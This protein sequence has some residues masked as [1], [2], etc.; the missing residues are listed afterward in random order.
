[1][2]NILKRHK[3][4]LSKKD[5]YTL[6]C[7]FYNESGGLLSSA[8]LYLPLPLKRHCVQVGTV[9]GLMAMQA[10]DWAIPAGM[11]REEYANAVR[12]GS[13]YHD[14]GAYLVYN[15]RGMYPDTG[16]RFLREQFAETEISPAAQQIILETVQSYGER[17]DGQG[18]PK[19]LAGDNIPLH[20]GIC[21]IADEIDCMIVGRHG[22]FINAAAD[23]KKYINEN[24]G[25]A[26]SPEAAGCFMTAYADIAGLYHHWR[27][28][29]PF[30]GNDNIKPLDKPIDRP[31]G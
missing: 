5:I 21:A 16:V 19:K 23:A 22:F 10:P 18:Y 31:I 3:F 20:A 28:H 30:W 14:I 7:F 2:K 11:T 1:M 24:K 17:Y 6:A 26:F 13:L 29:P 9:A 8:F 25:A 27:K 4:H 15:Q 12:Y